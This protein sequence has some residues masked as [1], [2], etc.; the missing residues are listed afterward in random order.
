M[1][2]AR[3][4]GWGG[5]HARDS[6]RQIAED[7]RVRTGFNTCEVEVLRA[8]EMLEFVAI[9]GN[10]EA[11]TAMLRRASPFAAMETALRLGADYG[12]WTFVAQE[13]LTPVARQQLTEYCWIPE[14]PDTDDP[15]QWRALDILVARIV[16]DHGRLRALMYLDEPVSGVRP[17]PARLSALAQDTRLSLRAVLTALEREELGQQVRLAGTAREVVRAASSQ[18]GY[19]D[20]LASAHGPL[21]S[22]LR[23][24]D[25]TVRVF[26][27]PPPAWPELSAAHVPQSLTNAVEAAARRAWATQSVVITEPG[28]VWGDEQLDRL[29]RH[30]LTRH[31]AQHGAGEMVVVPVGAGSEALGMLVVARELGGARWTESE[32]R[33]ALDI[34]H[35]LGRAIL[36]TRAHDRERELIA[37]LQRLGQYRAELISTVSHEL[38]NPLGVILGHIELLE[39]LELPEQATISIRALGRSASRLT[40]VMDDLLLLSR[41]GNSDH[42]LTREPVDLAAVVREV[43][44]T[45]PVRA[46]ADDVTLRPAPY[47]GPLV[48]PGD[49]E[50]PAPAVRQPGQQR[51]EVLPAGGLRRPLRRPGRRP[52]R[53]HLHRRRPRH[54]PG[55]PGPPVQRVLPLHQPRGPPPPRHRPR[56]GDRR[57]DRLPARRPDRRPSPSWVPAPLPGRVAGCSVAGRRSRASWAGRA[58]W[59]AVAPALSLDVRG[60]LGHKP[61]TDAEDVDP[62]DVPVC[63][64]VAPPHDR[65]VSADDLLLG[66]EAGVGGRGEERRPRGP[67]RFLALV[68]LPVGRCGALEDAVDG[69]RGHDRVHVVPVEGLVEASHHGRRRGLRE[70][71]HRLTRLHWRHQPCSA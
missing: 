38:K 42:P 51:G 11:D 58:A 15:D 10:D 7:V 45:E 40:S 62:A 71:G 46:D 19:V 4:D 56:P 24:Q 30:D 36:T 33:A 55:R 39:L 27:D 43:V 59:A 21:V 61:S 64:G 26:A 67:H 17:D 53:L 52:R 25:L 47:D 41:M 57:A 31:L 13:W 20:L 18:G 35:D 54:L 70:G 23:A 60:L 68:P 49:P 9:A 1:R 63:P 6:I 69:H 12:A 37:E 44:E 65:A 29:H 28:R 48:V 8:D 5:D 22:G 32:S 14:I 50:L 66:L 34:G 3:G 16:D 2:R